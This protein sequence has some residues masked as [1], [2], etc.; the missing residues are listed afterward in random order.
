M[1]YTY[2][3][4]NIVDAHI[5]DCEDNP[6]IICFDDDCDDNFGI[7][8]DKS[9]KYLAEVNIPTN[10]ITIIDKHKIY[11]NSIIVKNILKIEDISEDKKIK[12]VSFNYFGIDHVGKQTE[13]L[14]MCAARH[15]YRALQFI[16]DKTNEIYLEAFK[17]NVFAFK[18]L[19]ADLQTDYVC[20]SAV[21][22][23]PF[24]LKYVTYQNDVIC[25]SALESSGN[26]HYEI[27]QLINFDVCDSQLIKDFKKKHKFIY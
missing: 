10:A 27:M 15:D 3:K 13:K 7:N 11:T 9:Y 5:S 22:K 26:G 20:I 21:K 12:I 19:P 14:K 25:L 18:Y 2:M 4:H 1:I 23:Y 24:L 8:W 17:H 6:T 16:E